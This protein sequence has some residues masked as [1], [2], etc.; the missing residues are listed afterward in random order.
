MFFRDFTKYRTPIDMVS[1]LSISDSRCCFHTALIREQKSIE[2]KL[3][4]QLKTRIR[5]TGPLTVAEYMREVL[6]NPTSVSYLITLMLHLVLIYY[7]TKRSV[8]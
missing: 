6:T 7:I 1:L 3:C 4:E 5:M 8:R 2:T